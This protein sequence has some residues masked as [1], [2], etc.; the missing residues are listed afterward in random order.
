MGISVQ[1]DN[2]DRTSLRYVYEGR[3]TW[4]ELYR[5]VSEGNAMVGSV[6]HKVYIIIDVT[7]S[8]LIPQNALSQGMRVNAES[9]ANMGLRI[10]VGA[11]AFLRTLADVAAKVF[12]ATQGGKLNMRLVGTLDEARALIAAERKVAP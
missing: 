6:P 11:N 3:W 8:S 1:W 12:G 5:A 2:V 9:P 7:H 4:D 10:V